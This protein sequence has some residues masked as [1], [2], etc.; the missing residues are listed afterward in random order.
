MKNSGCSALLV[1]MML[2][3][4]SATAEQ[5]LAERADAYLEG[6]IREHRV[7]GISAAIAVDGEIVWV[8]A[9]GLADVERRIP[10]TTE[11]AFRIASISKV[12]TATAILQL[13]EQGTIDLN[14][15]VQ[16]YLPDYPPPRK[17][18][19][20]VGHLLAQTSGIRHSR[21]NESRLNTVHY[22]SLRDACRFFEDRK[23]ASAPGTKYRYSSYGF[24]VLGAV[25]E[26]A[27]GASFESYMAEHVWRPAGMSRTG[28][29]SRPV[30]DGKI[31]GLYRLDRGRVV[32]DVENDLSLIVPGGGM[33]AS[34]G[35]LLRFT[36]A[37]ETGQLLNPA[38][39]DLLLGRAPGSW[40]LPDAP[41]GWGWNAWEHE[42]HGHILSRVGGQSGTSAL[43]VSYAD[44]GVTVALLTN[45]ARFDPIWELINDLIGMGL[46]EKEDDGDLGAV[47]DTSRNAF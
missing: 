13:V 29:D 5:S 27:T 37:L 38:S 16:A 32:P 1:A 23:L 19:M 28:L 8:G 46:K 9:A 21:G 26:A 2:A 30:D 41:A 7:P 36:I 11:T 45:M 24:T 40:N 3:S 33:V 31:A 17:G 4:F 43:L 47:K 22:A 42:A 12:L 15:P 6:A 34:A 44:R 10:V 18:T 25:L 35:D 39:M 14:A 20:R